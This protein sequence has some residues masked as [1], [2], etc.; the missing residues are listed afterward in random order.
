MKTR[1]SLNCRFFQ[2]L[3]ETDWAEYKDSRNSV[4]RALIDAE[5]KQIYQELQSSKSNSRSLWKVINNNVPS[6]SQEKHV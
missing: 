1:D 6:K 3:S 2:T 4:K 5:R